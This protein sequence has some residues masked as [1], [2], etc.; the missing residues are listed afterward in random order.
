MFKIITEDWCE[1]CQKA[2]AMLEEL[3]LP[4]EELS[5][6]E[7][8]ELMRMHNCKTIPQVFFDGDYL[9]GGYEGLKRYLEQKVSSEIK[10]GW[11]SILGPW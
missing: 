2:K 11:S 3:R 5:L 9:P 10:K 7:G 6:E 8:S 4:Y 1:Y